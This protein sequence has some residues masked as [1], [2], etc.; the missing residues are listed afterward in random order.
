MVHSGNKSKQ[1]ILVRIG[2]ITLYDM[3]LDPDVIAFLTH[4]HIDALAYKL[5]YLPACSAFSLITHKE[6]VIPHIPNMTFR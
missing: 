2:R 6:Q 4:F 3:Y 5:P 1:S